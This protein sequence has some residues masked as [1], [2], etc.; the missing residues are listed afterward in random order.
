[1]YQLG[2]FSYAY[3]CQC[4]I[5]YYVGYADKP[6]FM[7]QVGAFTYAC[8]YQYVILY[9]ASY[10]YQPLLVDQLGAFTYLVSSRLGL[11]ALVHGSARSAYLLARLYVSLLEAI[12]LY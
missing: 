12:C 1:M 7:D 11:S 2:S 3:G 9:Q 8:G 10:G 4:V 6:L 5:L